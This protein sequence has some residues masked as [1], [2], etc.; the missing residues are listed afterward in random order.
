MRSALVVLVGSIVLVATALMT[1]PAPV[2]SKGAWPM[3]WKGDDKNWTSKPFVIRNRPGT[4]LQHNYVVLT[5]K[6]KPGR[7]RCV[8]KVGFRHKGVIKFPLEIESQSRRPKTVVGYWVFSVPDEVAF[9]RGRL[10]VKT[11]GGCLWWVTL[12]GPRKGEP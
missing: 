1:G 6:K 4:D 12:S 5:V 8:A 7:D 2:E 10:G 9:L 3:T 11:N